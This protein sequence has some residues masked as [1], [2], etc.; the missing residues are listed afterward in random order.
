MAKILDPLD[1][2]PA[3]HREAWAALAEKLAGK[4][5]MEAATSKPWWLEEGPSAGDSDA[6]R[7]SPTPTA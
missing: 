1:C 2:L 7:C 4:A 5:A 3:R 6:G